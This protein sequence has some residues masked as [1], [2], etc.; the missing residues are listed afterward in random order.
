MQARRFF[1]EDVILPGPVHF[2]AEIKFC[3]VLF[4]QIAERDG[5]AFGDVKLQDAAKVRPGMRLID[6]VILR[7]HARE[8][9][10]KIVPQHRPI[11]M[12]SQKRLHTSSWSGKTAALKR[13]LIQSISWG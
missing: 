11:A 7:F 3:R 12:K 1:F 10:G 5:D 9:A 2:K 4:F 8:I 13:R 6:E